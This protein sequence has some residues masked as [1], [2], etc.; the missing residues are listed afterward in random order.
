MCT[1]KHTYRKDRRASIEAEGVVGEDG[2]V[3]DYAA[4]LVGGHNPVEG[5]THISERTLEIERDGLGAHAG[6]VHGEDDRILLAQSEALHEVVHLL[7]I[8]EAA[9]EHPAG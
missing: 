3:H 9:G 5:E 4:V 8:V 1:A 2:V 6:E 7:Q